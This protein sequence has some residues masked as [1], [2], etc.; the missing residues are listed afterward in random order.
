MSTDTAQ[1]LP[2]VRLDPRQV[3][4]TLKKTVNYN[5]AGIGAGVLFDNSLPVGAFITQCLV[6]IVTAFNA[7]STNV[8]TVGTNSASF[9]N[10]VASGD[11]DETSV[12]VTSVA[13]GLGRSICASA[14][15]AVTAMYVQ[16]GTAA[17]TGKAVI[18]ICYEGG[19]QS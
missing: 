10:I 3:V 17:T 13:T 19:W 6:E 8:L 7:G 12:A 11:V 1:V 18:V 5:D 9:N 2:P 16:T 14:D 15:K 4:N